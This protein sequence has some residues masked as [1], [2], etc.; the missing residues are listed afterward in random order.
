MKAE[1]AKQITIANKPRADVINIK[2]SEKELDYVY[3]LIRDRA[4]HGYSY[5]KWD[6]RDSHDRKHIKEKLIG[7]GYSVSETQYP[8]LFI[9]WD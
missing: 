2:K 5:L 9:K 1:E 4:N 7:N 8:Y 6:Y 3:S